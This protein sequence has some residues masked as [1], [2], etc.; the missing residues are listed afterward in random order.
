MCYEILSF[1]SL[2]C[3]CE[4]EA[5]RKGFTHFGIANEA[6]CHGGNDKDVVKKF[7][8]GVECFG[9]DFKSCNDNDRNDC[10]GRPNFFYLYRVSNKGK[11]AYKI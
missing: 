11:V 4:K 8:K 3:R 2:I 9:Y 7:M 1:F 6:E 10:V 5:I